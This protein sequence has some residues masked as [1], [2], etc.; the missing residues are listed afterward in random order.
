M[1]C[2]S[3]KTSMYLN[4]VAGWERHVSSLTPF[5]L[6]LGSRGGARRALDSFS[7]GKGGS[8]CNVYPLPPYPTLLCCTFSTRDSAPRGSLYA[9]TSAGPRQ[10]IYCLALEPGEPAKG[11]GAGRAL[12]CA[13]AALGCTARGQP[14]PRRAPQ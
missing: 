11:P 13:A 10:N 4:C 5:R 14:V 9:P 7:R 8:R 12:L 2:F 6:D 3:E 1:V